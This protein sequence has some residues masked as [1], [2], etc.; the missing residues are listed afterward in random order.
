MTPF[1]VGLAGGSGSGKTTLAHRL[2][3][4]LPAGQG[5]VVPAD[6]Y[7][8]DLGHLP[9]GERAGRNFDE[10]AALDGERLAVDLRRLRA[11]EG[12][13]RPVYDFAAHTRRPE[14][15][16][17]PPRAVIVVEGI[18]VLALPAVRE[19]FH[20][21]VFVAAGETVRRER[22]IARDVGERGR[23]RESVSAQWARFT[24]PMHALHVAPCE[25]CADIVVSGE[26]DPAM[27]ADRVMGCIRSRVEPRERA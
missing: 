4:A 20:L 14:Q 22:R 7:Y 6:A 16:W 9:V 18:L 2:L 8:R 5:V 17:I 1:L 25:A 24:L 27:A 26:E 13:S 23:T 10:P 21:T 11:G 15:V 12:T 3:A 19:L